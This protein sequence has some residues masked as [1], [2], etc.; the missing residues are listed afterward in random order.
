MTFT[1]GRN[2]PGVFFAARERAV[3]ATGP[4]HRCAGVA[5]P[6]HRR[7]TAARDVPPAPRP[8]S[9]GTND[10]ALASAFLA[11]GITP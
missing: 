7:A 2:R 6:G 8:A 5:S 3:A 1:P 9:P 10:P 11:P 4:H